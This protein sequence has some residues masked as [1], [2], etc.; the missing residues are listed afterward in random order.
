MAAGC[1]HAGCA[2]NDWHALRDLLEPGWRDAANTGGG[3]ARPSVA[4]RLVEIGQEAELFHD[5]VGNAFARIRIAG[6]AE[7][8]LLRSKGFKRWLRIQYFTRYGK[9]PTGEGVDAALALLE[10]LAV[11]QG[12][13]HELQNRVAQ[14]GNDFL[15]DLTDDKWRAVR[16]T[17]GGWSIESEPPITLRRFAHQAAQVEPS[18]KGDLKLVL[19]FLNIRREDEPLL[20]TWLVAAFVPEIAHPIPDLHGEKGAGK[21]FGERVLRRII[22]PSAMQSLTFPSELK[23]LVQVLAHHYC[24]LFDNVD[25]LPAWLSDALCR[26]VTGEGFS[27]RELYSDDDD[28]IYKYRRVILLNGINVSSQRPDLLDRSIL[29]RLDRIE[30]SRRRPESEMW[31]EFERALPQIMAGVFDTLSSAMKIYPTLALARHERMADFTRWGAAI[32]VALGYDADAFI[33]A[34]SNNV[35]A[36]SQEAIDGNLVGSAI[37]ALM[38][39]Q[40]SWSGSPTDLLQELETVAVSVGLLRKPPPGGV[41]RQRG[42]PG[43][44]HILMRRVNEIR[45]NLLDLGIEVTETKNNTRQIAIRRSSAANAPAGG[46]GS[47]STPSVINLPAAG[48]VPNAAACAR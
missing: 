3:A 41:I 47:T 21:T 40:S 23:E 22:D 5:E 46:G 28:V 34:Y 27:K 38:E 17:A 30:R 9:A 14:D 11:F 25:S 7:I 39:S 44:P 29:I 15:Y 20:L 16:I 12:E 36:Q 48:G 2:G 43:G 19:K 6:H 31:E 4:D 37:V 18:D 10:A 32:S 1:H 26:A 45:S 24:P 42:W 13:R 35:G 8:H 33:D